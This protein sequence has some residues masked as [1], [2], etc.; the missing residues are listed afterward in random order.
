[1]YEANLEEEEE[2][3]GR[4]SDWLGGTFIEQHLYKHVYHE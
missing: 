2:E 3:E 1:M 4:V